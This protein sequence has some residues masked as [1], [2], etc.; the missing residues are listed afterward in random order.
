MIASNATTDRDLW[1]AAF[2]GE[3]RLGKSFFVAF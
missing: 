1:P 2:F 3:F